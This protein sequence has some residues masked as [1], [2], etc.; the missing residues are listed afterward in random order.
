MTRRPTG[1]TVGAGA[2]AVLVGN[3]VPLAGVRYWGWS[4]AAL[5]VVYWL[6]SGVVG[7]LT[8]PRIGLAGVD[9]P[10]RPALAALRAGETPG[11]SDAGFFVLHY[12]IFWVVHGVFVVVLVAGAVEELPFDGLGVPSPSVVAVG[13]LGLLGAHLGPFLAGYLADG[14]YRRTTPDREF[15]PPYARVVALHLTIVLGAVALAFVGTPL[16]L[17]VLL[18]VFKTVGELALLAWE[19][20]RRRPAVRAGGGTSGV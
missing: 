19:E 7:L 12:G 10:L 15:L 11:H 4:L 2:L 14:G 5:L 17:L 6:E 9:R 1:W 18:V 3:L 20:R 8:V 13:A 16:V